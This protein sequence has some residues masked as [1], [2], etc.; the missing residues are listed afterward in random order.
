MTALAARI[1]TSQVSIGRVFERALLAVRRNPGVTIG[2]V[3]LF[4]ALPGVALRL[5]IST[6]DPAALVMTVAGYALPG[7]IPL[8]LLSWFVDQVIG[9]VVQGAMVAP[10]LAEDQGR[11]AGFGESLAATMRALVPLVGFGALLGLGVEIGITLLIVPGILIYLMWCV[12][13][14]ALAAEREGIF[15]ALNRS[16]ELTQGSRWKIFGITLL[17]ETANILL[18]LAVAFAASRLLGIDLSVPRLGF[19]YVIIAGLL[20]IAVILV[21]ATVQASLYVELARSKE[22]GSVENLGEV[23]T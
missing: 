9:A 21:W 13:P 1:E 17:I 6:I 10:I 12:A 19:G 7:I 22:G 5:L 3:F 2:L 14:S 23:F 4:G 18:G 20:S 11:R 15:M 16:Q 8:A